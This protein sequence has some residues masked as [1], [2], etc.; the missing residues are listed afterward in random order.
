[1]RNTNVLLDSK[2][3]EIM[4]NVYNLGGNSNIMVVEIW[5]DKLTDQWKNSH[6]IQEVVD[7]VKNGGICFVTTSKDFNG[8]SIMA[9]SDMVTN[10]EIGNYDPISYIVRMTKHPDN[11]YIRFNT[12]TQLFEI[13]HY[14]PK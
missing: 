10:I 9:V 12:S 13:Y 1:M 6:T 11:D 4:K 8:G 7:F 3:Q 5:V 2:A 14:N